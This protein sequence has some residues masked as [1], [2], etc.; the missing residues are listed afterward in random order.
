MRILMALIVSHRNV[1]RTFGTDNDLVLVDMSDFSTRKLALTSAA[2]STGGQDR[3]IECWAVGTNYVWVTG[4]D[5]NEMY[6]VE[7][8]SANIADANIAKTVTNVSEGE[9]LFVD[10]F[11]RGAPWS[12]TP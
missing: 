11:G 2:E 9:I 3:H 1:N 6:I 7:L 8:P 10:N 12:S 4:G 5:A